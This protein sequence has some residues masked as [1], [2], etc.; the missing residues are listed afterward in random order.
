MPT[1][2]KSKKT[3]KKVVKELPSVVPNPSSQHLAYRAATNRLDYG[4]TMMYKD[5]IDPMLPLPVDFDAGIRTVCGTAVLETCLPKETPRELKMEI[6]DLLHSFGAQHYYC[7]LKCWGHPSLRVLAGKVIKESWG[8]NDADE[9]FGP[10]DVLNFSSSE[11]F[12]NEREREP[13]G[14]SLKVERPITTYDFKHTEKRYLHGE[15]GDG[16]VGFWTPREAVTAGIEYFLKSFA[17]GWILKWNYYYAHREGS[18]TEET[19][20]QILAGTPLDEAMAY[21]DEQ[22]GEFRK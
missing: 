12:G 14:I 8:K 18:A 13:K 1:K 22:L 5:D 11:H 9:I 16:T 7:D 20:F 10:G 2:T 17:P 21:L 3:V 19:D 4:Y 6:N 15:I